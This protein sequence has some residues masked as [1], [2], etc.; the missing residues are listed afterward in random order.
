MA[1][2]LREPL[3]HFLILG[4]LLYGLTGL[5][6]SSD[7]DPADD[8]LTID[9]ALREHLRERYQALHGNPPNAE[10]ESAL[11]RQWARDEVLLR[12]A[13][14]LGL[15]QGD[16]IVERRLLQ[17]MEF[18]LRA[19]IER[20]EPTDE[21]LGDWL[22]THPEA[23]RSE[24]SF[25]FEHHFFANA[26]EAE[27]RSRENRDA[28]APH[29]APHAPDSFLHGARFRQTPTSQ[30]RARF[31]EGFAATLAGLPTGEWSAPI[32]SAYGWHLV[33]IEASTPPA[34]ATLPEVRERVR[35]DLMEHQQAAAL[36]RA[37]DGI[38]TRYGI[39]PEGH[40]R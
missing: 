34:P 35:A 40:A 37:V 12:E 30:V 21:E 33:R 26:P 7:T 16:S 25:S 10:Q 28:Q 9:D 8:T 2:V 38:L 39:V 13:R 11:V 36:E 23:Y 1:R 17:M 24:G 32:Q 22:E 5:T 6:P 15:E 14:R 27:A 19:S 29:Q 18:S 31:G 3:V 20:A 4:A